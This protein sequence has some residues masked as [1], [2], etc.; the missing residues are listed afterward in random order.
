[1]KKYKE[2]IGFLIKL[3]ILGVVS[4]TISIIIK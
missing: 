2:E 3:I 1:M 4:I